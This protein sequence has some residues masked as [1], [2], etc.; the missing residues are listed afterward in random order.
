LSGSSVIAAIKYINFFALRRAVSTRNI[1]EYY[2]TFPARI[3]IAHHRS[4][5]LLNVALCGNNIVFLDYF[6]KYLLFLFISSYM[7]YS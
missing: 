6:F 3:G 2:C 1:P 4:F 7:L 5:H